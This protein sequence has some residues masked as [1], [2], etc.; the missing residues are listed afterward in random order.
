MNKKL[1]YLIIVLALIIIAVGAFYGINSKLN[2]GKEKEVQINPIQNYKNIDA[3]VEQNVASF[4]QIYS[5]LV[6]NK[7]VEMTYLSDVV[8]KNSDAYNI[9]VAEIM[10]L[11]KNS[12]QILIAITEIKIEQTAD[13]LYIANVTIDKLLTEGSDIDATPMNKII[14]TIKAQDGYKITEYKKVKA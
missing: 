12:A 6:N 2:K 8:D 1:K 7:T 5:N 13:N 11:R 3:Y 4:F 9:I 14:L 10:Q